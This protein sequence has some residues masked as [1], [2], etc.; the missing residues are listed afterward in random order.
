M[1]AEIA[2]TAITLFLANGFDATTID[3]V[4]AATG[5]ARRTF[6]RYFA[7]KEDVVLGYLTDLGDTLCTALAAR[8]PQEPV[9]EALRRAMDDAKSMF[10]SD[11]AR[12]KAILS[13]CDDTPSLRARHAEKAG[14]WRR[15]ITVELARRLHVDP[16]TD[17]RPATYAAAAL[18]ALDAV[19]EAW[20]GARHDTD[21]DTLLDEAFAALRG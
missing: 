8:P 21:I 11:P 17:L 5:V 7:T 16:A 19:S 4:A 12:M 2:T 3:D 1:R 6:F 9:W 10:M 13:L 20:H 14:H 18:G 15:G